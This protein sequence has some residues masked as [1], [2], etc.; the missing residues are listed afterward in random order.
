MA[1]RVKSA[2]RA[3]RRTC[4]EE[5]QSI[6]A[7]AHD[8]FDSDRTLGV[9]ARAGSRRARRAHRDRGEPGVGGER[10]RGGSARAHARAALAGVFAGGRGFAGRAKRDDL[11]L[12]HSHSADDG[13]PRSAGRDRGGPGLGAS[14]DGDGRASARRVQRRG[15]GAEGA[16]DPRRDLAQRQRGVRAARTD[17]RAAVR[18]WAG[19]A[20]SRGVERARLRGAPRGVAAR[21][22]RMGLGGH[23]REDPRALRG[24][25][26]PPR[27]EAR[28]RQRDVLLR[29]VEER[30][31]GREHAA[32]L[33]CAARRH[34]GAAAQDE[35]RAQR[36][37]GD[38]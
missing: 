33:L 13:A 20:L 4:H 27:H 17:V 34:H 2:H 12:E 29:P 11:A 35:P 24:W 36:P 26:H 3:L 30:V 14:N 28:T 37:R 21:D 38:G 1:L 31:R 10:S 5:P 25:S 9:R 32:Q 8:P 19:G 23:R 22:Q 18:R 7:R 6:D 15:S 16:Q